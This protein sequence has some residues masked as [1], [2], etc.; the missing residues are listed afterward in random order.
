[1]HEYRDFIVQ[2]PEMDGKKFGM[3][4]EVGDANKIIIMKSNQKRQITEPNG[5]RVDNIQLD[6][7]E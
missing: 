5:R 7:T 1:M 3:L 6:L 2:E 4:R